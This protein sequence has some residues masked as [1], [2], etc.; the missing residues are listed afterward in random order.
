MAGSCAEYDWGCGYCSEKTTPL[1][2]GTLY[3]SCKKALF[4]ILMSYARQKGLSASWGRVFFLYGPHEHSSRI[5]PS[6]INA[7]LDGRVAACTSG[8]QIRDF[9][10]V[11]DVAQAFSALLDSGVD[12]AVNIASGEAVE[13]KEIILLI[14]EK[15]GRTDLVQLG[16]VPMPESEPQVLVADNQRLRQETGWHRQHSLESGL[17]KSID[18]W[19]RNRSRHS[20][21]FNKLATLGKGGQ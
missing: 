6:I 2:P 11:E 21:S 5:V 7:L 9:C 18:W 14:A 19:A 15:M 12:G 10:Y 17:E 8:T 13:L 1:N 3:G 4:E 16:A 20:S